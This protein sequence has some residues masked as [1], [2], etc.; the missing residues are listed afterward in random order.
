MSRKSG[1]SG[2]SVTKFASLPIEL[3]FDSVV[4]AGFQERAGGAHFTM[5][6][7]DHGPQNDVLQ[8]DSEPA[9]GEGFSNQG[10][11]QLIH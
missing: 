8:H 2:L 7:R 10:V 11:G 9:R 6:L 3:Y 1:G 5:L 4:I